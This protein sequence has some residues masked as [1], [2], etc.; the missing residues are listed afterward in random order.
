MVPRM[1]TRKTK[2]VTRKR[3]ARKKTSGHGRPSESRDG[4][5]RKMRYVRYSDAE[6]AWA[7]KAAKR[8]SLPVSAYV[9]EPS[10]E[11]MPITN[12]AART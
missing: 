4:G 2:K 5:V 11:G 1:A 3:K 10:I 6:W 12:P 9:R 8:L 7:S